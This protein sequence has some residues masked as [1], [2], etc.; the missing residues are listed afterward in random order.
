MLIQDRNASRVSDLKSLIR[1]ITE[2]SWCGEIT[3]S[4]CQWF[5]AEMKAD[6][7]DEEKLK[8]MDS[9]KDRHAGSI[10]C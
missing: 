1:E 4:E 6:A 7:T 10:N 5:G 9:N 8:T 2:E 3:I